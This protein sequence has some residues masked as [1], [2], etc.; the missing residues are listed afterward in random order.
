M[1]LVSDNLDWWN[2]SGFMKHSMDAIE[3]KNLQTWA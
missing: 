2:Q 3:K 1:Y